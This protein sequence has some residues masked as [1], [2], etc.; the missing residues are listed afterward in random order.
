M[1][2][3][4]GKSNYIKKIISKRVRECVYSKFTQGAEECEIQ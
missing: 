2:Q 4:L 1:K 3:S